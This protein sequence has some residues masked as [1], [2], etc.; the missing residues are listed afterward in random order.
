MRT[1]TTELI[2]HLENVDGEVVW[3]AVTPDVAGFSATASSL[4]ELRN[5]VTAALEEILEEPVTIVERLEGVQIVRR[6][7]G[8]WDVRVAQTD[9]VPA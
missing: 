4:S 1:M 9:L 8:H 2:I 5:R 6:D 7:A 3:W